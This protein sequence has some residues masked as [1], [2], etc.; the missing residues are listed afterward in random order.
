[1]ELNPE[2]RPLRPLED[3][4]SGLFAYQFQYPLGIM[5]AV[6]AHNMAEAVSVLNVLG[7]E[8]FSITRVGV[9]VNP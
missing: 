8:P 5:Q 1:M 2:D 7:I 4:Q 6:I 3:Q 9:V